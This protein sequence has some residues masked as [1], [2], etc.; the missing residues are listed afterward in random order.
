MSRRLRV[1]LPYFLFSIFCFLPCALC[2]QE[3][4]QEVV[5][6]LAAGRVVIFVAKDGIAIAANESHIEADSRPPLVAQLSGKR[7]AILLGAVEWVL[8]ASGRPPLRLDFELPRAIAPLTGGARLQQEQAS[9]LEP[10]GTALLEPLR[11]VV[12]Q[13]TRKMDLAPEESLVEMLVV[14][15]EEQYGP[16]VWL[17]KYRLAQE[18][19]RGDFWRSRVLRPSY[20]QLYPPEKGQPRTLVEVRYPPEESAPALLDLFQQSDARLTPLRTSNV[21]VA[22]ASEKLARGESN[23]A[24]LDDAVVFLR[25]SLDAIAQPDTLQIVAVIKETRGFEWILAPPAALQQKAEDVKPREPGAP[26]LRK[27]PPQ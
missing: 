11:T 20:T 2:A 23:K 12:P 18:P 16:E 8:P 9:D 17:L 26:S 7:I 10:I 3:A 6:N 24:L 19:L 13:L 1:W 14:G 25:A 15:Y 27:K 22:R 5:A 4:G 21:Q